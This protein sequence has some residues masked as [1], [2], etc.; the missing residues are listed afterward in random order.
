MGRQALRITADTNLLVRATTD[1]D[2]VQA[3]AAR[4]CLAA[5][6]RVVIPA[7]VICEFAWVLGRGYKYSKEQQHSAIQRYVEASSV[8]I[9]R[10]AVEDGLRILRAGGDFS[11]GVIAH[12]G[13][14]RGGDVFATFDQTA[15]RLL[16]GFGYSAICPA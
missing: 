2:P 5:A 11:D 10:A 15:S 14:A 7:P 6:E 16:S 3:Q 8:V 12:Q 4:A 13:R 1:D 9:D